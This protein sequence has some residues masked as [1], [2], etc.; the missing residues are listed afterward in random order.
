[1]LALAVLAAFTTAPTA[2]S[3]AEQRILEGRDE[4]A[5]PTVKTSSGEVKG[6]LVEGCRVFRGVPFAEP[7][8]GAL[9]WRAP[10][11]KAPWSGVRDATKAAAQCP[12]L[13]ILRGEHFG[14]EDCLYLSVYAPPSCTAESP[15]ATM[16]WIYGGAWTIG[17]NG[18]FGLYTGEH[19]A[20]QHGVVVIASNY[21][22][23]VLGWLAL[24]ELADEAT[25]SYANYGLQD[26]RLAMRWARA[27]AAAFGGDRSRLTIF[28]ES[29]GA[30]SVCQHL[31]SPASDGLF[32][33]AIME[34]GDCDGPWLIQDG[35]SAKRFGDDYATLVGCPPSATPGERAVCLRRLSPAQVMEP[36]SSWLCPKH[37]PRPDDPWCN[38]T[39]GVWRPWPATRPAMAPVAGWTAVVDGTAEGLLDTPYNLMRRGRINRGPDGKPLQLIMGTN[40]DE[41]ALFLASLD[42]VSWQLTSS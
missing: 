24:E 18:E 33:R 37:L 20:M 7:P 19:L 13:D 5:A 39:N 14:S 11:P 15:C 40:Q 42:L 4:T 8:V 30:F 3:S 6:H 16:F 29:A 26:Q 9:R 36:Y 41:M 12:Q 27:N 21:R 32:S 34:S 22:L 35:G 23:D 25:G 31:T 1:M 2:A 28:G 10:T 17:G 38:G